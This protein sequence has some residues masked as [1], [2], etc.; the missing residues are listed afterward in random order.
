MF[1]HHVSETSTSI[2]SSR[3]SPTRSSQLPEL[4][5]TPGQCGDKYTDIAHDKTRRRLF[6]DTPEHDPP[7][8]V[9]LHEWIDQK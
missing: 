4:R 2:N 3:L 7:H 6:L 8:K 5:T 1:Q 9:L